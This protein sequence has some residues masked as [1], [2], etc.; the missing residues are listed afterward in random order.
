M[1]LLVAPAIT[2][3]PNK[4]AID[5]ENNIEYSIHKNSRTKKPRLRQN[6]TTTK[7]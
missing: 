4:P 2:G 6:L 7:I 3:A 5:I 1:A